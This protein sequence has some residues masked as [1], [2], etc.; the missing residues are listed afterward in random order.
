MSRGDGKVVALSVKSAKNGMCMTV[1][2]VIFTMTNTQAV[3]PRDCRKT[4]A[5]LCQMRATGGLITYMHIHVHHF[6]CIYPRISV[7]NLEVMGFKG[8]GWKP[9]L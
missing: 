8:H 4:S 7:L 1:G 2:H 6:S 5:M 3:E 9:Y